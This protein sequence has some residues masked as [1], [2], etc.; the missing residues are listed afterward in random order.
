MPPADDDGTVPDM[1]EEQ[2]GAEARHRRKF[3]VVV[4][5]TPECDRAVVYAAKRAERTGG[6]LLLLCIVGPTEF[7]HWLGVQDRMREEAYEEATALL[8]KFAERAASVAAI[9]PLTRIREGVTAEEVRREIAEDRDIAILVLA[10]GTGREGPGPLV[11]AIASRDRA[12]AYPIPVTVVPGDLSDEDIA[13][14]T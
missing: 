13:A 14:L 3:L 8:E 11:S 9:E 4:D 2:R 5:D 10:A 7:E 12:N 6:A 1:E